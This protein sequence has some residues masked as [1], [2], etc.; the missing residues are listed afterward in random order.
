MVARVPL[1]SAGA[2]VSEAM[3]L[4]EHGEPVGPELLYRVSTLREAAQPY[5]QG[6][7]R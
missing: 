7:R 3:A 1:S 2:A 4:E 6:V 5:L